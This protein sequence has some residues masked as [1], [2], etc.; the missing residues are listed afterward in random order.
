MKKIV[1]EETEIFLELSELCA[2]PGYVHAIAYFCFRDNTV[3]YNEKL[4]SD[5]LLQQFSEERLVRTELSTIIGLTCKSQISTDL[6]SPD[7]IQ[8]YIQ[9]TETLLQEIHQSMMPPMEEIF[10]PNKIDDPSFNPFKSGKSLREPIFYSAES[11]YY[12]QYRDLSKEKYKKDTDWFSKNKGF[13]IQQ[14]LDVIASLQSLLN[15]KIN[16]LLKK[17]E[18]E[19]SESTFLSGYT[20]TA[21]EISENSNIDIDIVSKIIESFVSSIDMASFNSL[22]DFNP[23]NAYPIIRLSKGEY[24]L[25]KIY[26]LMEALYE[27]PFFWFKDDNKYASVAMQHR[28]EFTEEFS[29]E[30]LK[31]VFGKNHVFSNIDIYDSKS[32]AG[33]IDVLVIFANK[34]IVLQAKSKKLTIAARKGNDN[35]LQSDFKK[36]VQ[37]AYNQAYSCAEL[38]QN[39]DCKLTDKNGNTLNINREYKEIYLFC[40]VSDHY[41]AL[42]F[43]SKHFLEL[44]NSEDNIIKTPFIMDVF[45][46]DVMTEILQSPLHFL[47]YVNRR[48]LY[49]E[50]IFSAH[51]L[52]V[53]SYHLKYNLWFEDEYSMIQ[54]EDDI[55][56]DLDLAMLTRRENV[57]GSDTPEGILTRYK[58]TEFD[59]ILKGI[60][61]LE[62]SSV[63]DLGFMLLALS[64]DTIERLNDGVFQLIELGKKDGRHHDL[65]LFMSSANGSGLTIHCNDDHEYIS[66]P[67]LEKHCERRKYAQK[68]NSWFGLCI[69]Q[70]VPRV[71]FGINKEYTW[72]QSD[73]MDRLVEDLPQPQNLEGKKKISFAATSASAKKTKRKI[74]RNEKCLCGSGKKYKNCCL[75]QPWKIQNHRH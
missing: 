10:N 71:R 19:H 75:R 59:R 52:T 31:L 42:S 21:Q 47:N 34:A 68:A 9:K 4:T 22:D 33:E 25:F 44:Y 20:F 51:E 63:I 27:T 14:A 3:R 15:N 11:A 60:E 5:D 23:T 2:S 1:R 29:A 62:H 17:N 64:S 74:G 50:K 39:K 55:C 38:L 16:D 36:A 43:Q 26:S 28:G 35:N 40:V 32:K 70:A 49:G 73:S 13:S 46:L 66:V 18:K 69:G 7:L 61:K 54:L 53:L 67:R 56:V 24:L 65:T 12:F 57:P 6:P 8:E 45:L 37:D 58:D 72:A 30:R 48:T 41:P